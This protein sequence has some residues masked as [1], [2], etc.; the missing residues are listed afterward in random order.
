MKEAHMKT[1]ETEIR[2]EP[3]TTLCHVLSM[4]IKHWLTVIALILFSMAFCMVVFAAESGQCLDSCEAPG[5]FA[6][7][8]NLSQRQREGLQQ[9]ADQFST[10]TAATRGKIMEKR[11]ELKRLSNDPEANVYAIK[12][13][14]RE[15]NVLEQGFS[16]KIHQIEIEHRKIL[17]REQINKMKNMPNGYDSQGYGRRP[18]GR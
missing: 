14:D 2:V 13:V 9:L 16:R 1:T 6:A 17:T 4:P 8:L 5:G 18:N 10:D 15:L 3:A 12:K 11:L 7:T